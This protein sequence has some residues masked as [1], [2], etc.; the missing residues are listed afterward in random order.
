MSDVRG[1]EG[2]YGCYRIRQSDEKSEGN[3][4]GECPEKA[5]VRKRAEGGDKSRRSE[6][7]QVILQEKM[8]KV[9]MRVG[10]TYYDVVRMK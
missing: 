2:A 8:R 1:L 3:V 10:S 5:K 7:T 4:R 6:I 9:S